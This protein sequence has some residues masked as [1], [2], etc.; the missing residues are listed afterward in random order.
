M[1]KKYLN[2]FQSPTARIYLESELEKNPNNVEANILLGKIYSELDRDDLAFIHFKKALKEEPNNL[3]LLLEIVITCINELD[4][5]EAMQYLHNWIKFHPE[6][7]KYLDPMNLMLNPERIL[8]ESK[9]TLENEEGFY[10]NYIRI[11]TMKSDFYG[12]MLKLIEF[13]APNYKNDCKLWIVLG[14][15]HFVYY[16]Y[17]RAEECFVTAVNMNP[18]DYS[19][20][21]KL[22]AIQSFNQNYKEAISSYKKALEINPNYAKCWNNLGIGYTNLNQIDEAIYS[23]LKAL[24]VIEDIPSSWSYLQVLFIKDDKPYLHDLVDKRN[25]DEL[26]EHFNV[27]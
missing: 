21:N 15:I 12:E 2:D 9:N 24:K 7:K 23:H 16:N 13:V 1:A 18:N 10:D 26:C 17:V 27:K 11:E 20:L 25:L 8:I 3:D 14:V 4:Q 22:G 19:A 5:F 6:Y